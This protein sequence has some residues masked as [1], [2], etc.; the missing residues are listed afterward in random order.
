MAVDAVHGVPAG[1]P[2]ESLPRLPPAA[3]P[4]VDWPPD[5]R[6]PRRRLAAGLRS[7]SPSGFAGRSLRQ[8][9]AAEGFVLGAL[10][11]FPQARR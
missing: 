11:D 4:R 8:A 10:R 3:V 9:L 7:S 5:E 2:L 1:V 6:P